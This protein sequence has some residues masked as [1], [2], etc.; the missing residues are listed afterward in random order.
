MKVFN[1][2][3]IKEMV[4]ANRVGVAPMCTYMC[5]T[6]DG[7]AGDFH[8]AHYT[9]FA[10]GQ[11]GLIIQEATTVNRDGYISPHCLGIYTEDQKAALRKVVHSVHQ[12]PTKIGIQLNHAG[13]KTKRK[14][15]RTLSASANEQGVEEASIADIQKIVADFKMAA[16]S[17]QDIGYDFVEIHGAHG[18]L[19]NQFL[20]PLTNHRQD[21]YGKNRHLLLQ[22][23]VES[24]KEVFTGPVFVRLSGDEYHP[25]GNHLVDTQKTAILLKQLGVDLVNVSSGGVVITTIEPYP[26]YQVHLASGVKEAA[27]IPVA[28][29]GLITQRAQI[30]SIIENHQADIVLCGRLLARDPFFLLKWRSD[31]DLLVQEDVPIH[32]WRSIKAS[33]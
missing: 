9:T 25:D 6:E 10:M 24:V 13:A 11:P 23:V 27:S 12:F 15:R 22:Q 32:L 20:S 21:E 7:V 1:P 16:L 2:L 4:I 18:Y 31:L 26:L 30:T 14:D 8:L 17:A 5:K 28:T 19:I 33:K 29:A 3:T